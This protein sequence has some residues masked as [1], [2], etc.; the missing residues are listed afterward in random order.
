MR[1]TLWCLH[2]WDLKFGGDGMGGYRGNDKDYLNWIKA[3]LVIALFF[4]FGGVSQAQNCGQTRFTCT[5]TKTITMTPTLTYTVTVTPTFTG[6]V[7]TPTITNTPTA[8]PTATNTRTTTPGASHTATPSFTP[9]PNAT[10]VALFKDGS[11]RTFSAYHA[12]NT[13]NWLFGKSLYTDSAPGGYANF[14]SPN[15]AYYTSEP[16]GGGAIELDPNGAIEMFTDSGQYLTLDGAEGILLNSSSGIILTDCAFQFGGDIDADGNELT[17]HGGNINTQGGTIKNNGTDGSLVLDYSQNAPTGSVTFI[18]PL[19]GSP[20]FD[21]NGNL[22][23]AGGKVTTS[24]VTVTGTTVYIQMTP[25]I[26]K[27]ATVLIALTP[28]VINYLG[29]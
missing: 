23:M 1:F 8:S 15:G 4:A 21:S 9:T 12:F 26:H 3:M 25:Y 18:S 28:T 17:M 5:P 13:N 20:Y 2:Y 29:Y 6:T 19:G 27:S 11:G 24:A 16:I 7:N 22:N 14:Q 10:N